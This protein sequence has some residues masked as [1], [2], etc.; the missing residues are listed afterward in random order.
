[1]MIGVFIKQL[2]VLNLKLE[3]SENEAKQSLSLMHQMKTNQ[4]VLLI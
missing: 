2:K 1:M 3:H 4:L